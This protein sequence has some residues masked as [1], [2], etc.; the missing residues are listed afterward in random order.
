MDAVLLNYISLQKVIKS[1]VKYF[2][3]KV[4]ST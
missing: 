4:T 2:T 3:M 1:G